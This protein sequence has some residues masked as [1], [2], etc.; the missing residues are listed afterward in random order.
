MKNHQQAG[1]KLGMRIDGALCAPGHGRLQM[2]K[3][4]V[5]LW[6]TKMGLLFIMSISKLVT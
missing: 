6:A 2:P 4:S 3:F 1:L 5:D